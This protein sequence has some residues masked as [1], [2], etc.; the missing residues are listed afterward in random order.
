MSERINKIM[1]II[2][3]HDIIL[4]GKAKGYS[5][6]LCPLC[7][8]HLTLLYK[9]N[10]DP[11][12]IY[13]TDGEYEERKPE[14]VRSLYGHISQNAYC[15]LIKVNDMPVGECWLQKMNYKEVINK[16]TDQDIRRIDMVIGNKNW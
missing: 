3:S 4:R 11:E 13:G 6:T 12:V 1:S 8:E 16:Y 2:K 14:S 10:A 7:D 15:F 9:W 5:V